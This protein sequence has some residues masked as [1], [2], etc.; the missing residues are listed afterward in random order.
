MDLVQSR[1]IKVTRTY[2]A[3]AS[4]RARLLCS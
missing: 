3:K 2:Q 1:T 4:H